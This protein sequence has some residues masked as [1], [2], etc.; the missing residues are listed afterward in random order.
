VKNIDERKL[1]QFGVV[2]HNDAEFRCTPEANAE[3]LPDYLQG[4]VLTARTFLPQ[5][6]GDVLSL[7]F[8]VGEVDEP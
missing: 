1:T 3:L 5:L 7:V 2:Y 8:S 6:L 4:D